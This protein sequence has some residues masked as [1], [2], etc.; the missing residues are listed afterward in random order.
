M[1]PLLIAVAT[2]VVV[3]TALWWRYVRVD[4]RVEVSDKKHGGQLVASVLQAHGSVVDDVI[5]VSFARWCS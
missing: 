4:G 3:L 5:S 1:D 2:V